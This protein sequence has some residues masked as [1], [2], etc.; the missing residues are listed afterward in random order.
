[1]SDILH[2]PVDRSSPRSLRSPDAVLD[3]ATSAVVEQAV[4]A[5]SAEAYARGRADGHRDALEDR[6]RL[7]SSIEAAIAAARADLA[8]HRDQTIAASLELAREVAAAVLDRTPPDDAVQLVERV[9]DTLSLLEANDLEVAVH[10]DDH[11]EVSEQMPAVGGVRWRPDAT[12]GRG[13]AQIRTPY[14]GAVLTR[15]ALLE[16]A[17]VVLEGQ[18]R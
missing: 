2:L 1:M 7:R 13:E 4:A 9:R 6:D 8:E 3:P 17:M 18:A 12:L 11:G 16:A 15:A 5:A 14:G 10:P